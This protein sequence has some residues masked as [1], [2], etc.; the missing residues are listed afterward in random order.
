MSDPTIHSIWYRVKDVDSLLIKIMEKSV[1]V[2]V[3]TQSNADIEKYRYISEENHYK[4]ITDLV[5]E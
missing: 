4:I 3:E 2:P 5:A 1:K